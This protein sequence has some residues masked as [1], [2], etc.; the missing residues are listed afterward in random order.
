VTVSGTF[1]I[2]SIIAGAQLTTS[3]ALSGSY[4]W[5]YSNTISMSIP[6]YR[7]GNAVDG[8]WRWKTYGHYYYLSPTCAVSSSQYITTYVPENASGWKTW[9]STT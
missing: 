5:S 9:I 4:S 8:A 3:V 6:A 1:N 2:N 7:Y